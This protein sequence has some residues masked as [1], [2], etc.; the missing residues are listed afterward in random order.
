[1]KKG[2]GLL[3]IVRDELVAAKISELMLDIGKRLDASILLV[4]QNCSPQEFNAYRTVVGRLM[5]EI[6]LEI[7]NPLYSQHT[8]LKP[9]ELA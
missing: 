8:S 7:L 6:L 9:P 5:G 3:N 4:M 2:G 1:V